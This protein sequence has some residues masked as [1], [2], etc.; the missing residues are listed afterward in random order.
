MHFQKSHWW[1]CQQTWVNQVADK[2]LRFYPGVSRFVNVGI[3]GHYSFFYWGK[4]SYLDSKYVIWMVSIAC[5]VYIYIYQ[6]CLL[7]GASSATKVVLA[8]W[9]SHAPNGF[10]REMCLPNLVWC[11]QHTFRFG[12]TSQCLT[13]SLKCKVSILYLKPEG[14]RGT[15]TVAWGI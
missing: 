13:S 5:T 10:C 3:D 8:Q 2:L 7:K 11:F 4:L 12:K 6:C 1:F 14:S 9:T 15:L